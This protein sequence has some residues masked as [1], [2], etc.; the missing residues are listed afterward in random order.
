ME[1]LSLHILDIAENSISAGASL[2]FITIEE[3]NEA[4]AVTVSDNGTGMKKEI[5]QKCETPYFSTKGSRGIGISLFKREA[6][7][8]GGNIKISSKF[9]DDF[10]NSH[11]TKIEALFY[12]NHE[13]SLPLGDI[14]ASVAA[15]ILGSEETDIVFVHE[16]PNNRIVFDTRE[17]RKILGDIRLSNP[18]VIEFLK[19]YLSDLYEQDN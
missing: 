12:K 9:I 7:K 3:T 19:N 16:M 15:L 5:L 14:S 11:G 13:A 1:E 6:E 8:T 4:Y 10:P 2:V 18:K 17:I